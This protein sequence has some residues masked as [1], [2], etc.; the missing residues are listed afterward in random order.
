MNNVRDN[1]VKKN[2]FHK[3]RYLICLHEV[4]DGKIVTSNKI[5][6]DEGFKFFFGYKID[7]KVKPQQPLQPMSCFIKNK[8]LLKT[9]NK[10]RDETKNIMQ[11]EFDSE[12]VYNQN[13]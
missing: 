9:Y 7:N 8:K 11:K 12:P 3:S 6:D 4:K 13:F 1:V 5:Q 2:P 10:V